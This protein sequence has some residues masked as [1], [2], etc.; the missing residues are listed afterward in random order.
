MG[1]LYEIEGDFR[2][3]VEHSDVDMAVQ[4][5]NCF[6]VM[7]T[8]VARG[9]ADRFPEIKAADQATTRGDVN[10]LGNF[11]ATKIQRNLPRVLTFVNVYGQYRYS[12]T[13]VVF[14][15]PKFIKGLGLAVDRYWPTK[16]VMPHV[17]AGA[18]GGDI[19][20]LRV[21][22]SE[23][24]KSREC[25]IYLVKYNRKV[26]KVICAGSR[27]FSPTSCSG[28][29]AVSRTLDEELKK[30]PI[31]IISGL[32]NGPDKYGKAWSN[33]NKLLSLDFKANWTSRS[34]GFIRNAEMGKIATDAIV[35][36]DGESPGSN[37][38]IEFMRKKKKPVTIKR[39]TDE[40]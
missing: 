16:I 5:C 22:L 24:V 20:E 31:C 36:W 17:G 34:A 33:R 26:R 8:G 11:S 19:N 39:E 40:Y 37:H 3:F 25:D 30:G 18:A 29:L 13:E 14:S 7:G 23:F 15:L 4:N 9:L 12:W 2:D 32:A 1:S 27:S 35:F 21:A 6:N 28:N 10:K 38:M